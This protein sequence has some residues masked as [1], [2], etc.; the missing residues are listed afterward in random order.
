MVE[1][2]IELHGFYQ[3]Q[4]AF[5]SAIVFQPVVTVSHISP[6][7]FL[8]DGFIYCAQDFQRDNHFS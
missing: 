3:E 2:F 8:Q 1:S 7:T 4:K 5:L 6:F